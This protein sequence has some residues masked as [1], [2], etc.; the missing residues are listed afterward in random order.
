MARN[1]FL[2]NLKRAQAAK[3]SE[4]EPAEARPTEQV[5]DD[6]LEEAVAAARRQLLDAQHQELRDREIARVSAS[7]SSPKGVRQ[8]PPEASL[9]DVLREKQRKK[10]RTWR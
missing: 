8:A 3:T 4:S 10:R 9:A 7:G 5:T 1:N 6:E 2:E